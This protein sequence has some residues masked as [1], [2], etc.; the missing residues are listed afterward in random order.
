MLNLC[1]I[2]NWG[3]QLVAHDPQRFCLS[4]IS[5]ICLSSEF[6]GAPLGSRSRWSWTA[7]ASW[8]RWALPCWREWPRCSCWPVRWDRWTWTCTT[9]QRTASSCSPWP[10]TDR[11]SPWGRRVRSGLDTSISTDTWLAWIMS[12]AQSPPPRAPSHKVDLV[13]KGFDLLLQV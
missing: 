12:W 6:V 10:R 1:K 13:Q 9:L 8:T 7:A 3:N 5:W 2:K 4:S 11:E